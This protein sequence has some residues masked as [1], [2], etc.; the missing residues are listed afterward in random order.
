MSNF[1][2]RVANDYGEF[3]DRLCHNAPGTND[4]TT[5]DLHAI[6]QNCAGSDPHIITNVYPTSIS[7]SLISDRD[8]SICELMISC[9]H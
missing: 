1:T 9:E 5:T 8:S 4:S 6:K 2:S 3:R 7:H